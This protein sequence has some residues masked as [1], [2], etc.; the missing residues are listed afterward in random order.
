MEHVGRHMEK[1]RRPEMLDFKMWRQDPELQVWL[2]EEG[3]I[4]WENPAGWKI[5]N[6]RPR[7]DSIFEGNAGEM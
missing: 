2:Q 7:R 5:G 3:L 4:A 1:D 6:G